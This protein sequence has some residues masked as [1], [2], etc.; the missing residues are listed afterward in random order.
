MKDGLKTI[1]FTIHVQIIISILVLILLISG[2]GPIVLHS[3]IYINTL[4]YALILGLI[5]FLLAF[6]LIILKPQI[7]EYPYKSIL[8]TILLLFFYTL[9]FILSTSNF[10]LWRI[11]FLTHLPITWF[12]RSWL[13]TQFD[14]SQQFLIGLWA[15]SPG[16]GTKLAFSLGTWI[17]N[18]KNKIR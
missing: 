2:V 9:S 18:R 8:L 17:N 13:P 4:V 14:W 16:L 5:Y 3:N 12:I 1:L 7:S 11:Y 15:L 6:V 10:N